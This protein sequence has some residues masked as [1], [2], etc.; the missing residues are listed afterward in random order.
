MVL[1]M[2]RRFVP[3]LN[4][5]LILPIIFVATISTVC[6]MEVHDQNELIV[7]VPSEL[8]HIRA[9]RASK[10]TTVDTMTTEEKD[11]LWFGFFVI[12]GFILMIIQLYT[13]IFGRRMRNEGTRWH[14]LYVTI[15]MILNL[16]SHFA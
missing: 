9:K 3:R 13:T 8:E 11:D 15:F 4:P 10:T 2:A 16:V 5:T 14:V 7:E 6:S 1:T 12:F